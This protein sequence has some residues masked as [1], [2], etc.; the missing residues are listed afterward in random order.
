MC[1]GCMACMAATKRSSI[2]NVV[3]WCWVLALL[4]ARSCTKITEAEDDDDSSLTQPTTRLPNSFLGNRRIHNFL[5]AFCLSFCHNATF[6]SGVEN[7]PL[8]K[9]PLYVTDRLSY[10]FYSMSVALPEPGCVVGLRVSIARRTMS[11]DR[12]GW[13][14]QLRKYRQASQ[15][16]TKIMHA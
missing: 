2:I 14:A 7:H 13:Y 1:D 3:C 6:V 15:G 12:E 11:S 5:F 4:C 8:D 16:V 10:N 9:F